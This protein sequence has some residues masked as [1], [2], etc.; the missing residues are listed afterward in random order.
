[1]KLIDAI[2][3]V[4]PHQ[5]V[6]TAIVAP[7][8]PNCM[9]AG[10][11]PTVLIELVA[12]TAGLAVGLSEMQ[13]RNNDAQGQGWL[14]G[15]KHARFLVDHIPLRT[16]I[17]IMIVTQPKFE[18]FV[19]IHGEAFINSERVAEIDLQVLISAPDSSR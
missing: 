2:V 15:I 6:A 3:K 1:M 9:D 5:A 13:T 18:N 19:Q 11:D 10:A 4:E 8:W 12:Q 14:V 16:Q 17:T 7:S